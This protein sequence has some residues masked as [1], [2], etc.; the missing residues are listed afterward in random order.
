MEQTRAG[1]QTLYTDPERTQDDR[2]VKWRVVDGKQPLDL[3]KKGVY[4]FYYVP[5]RHGGPA[6][7][8]VD[9]T[10]TPST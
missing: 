2:T 4:S 10:G 6:T 7:A 9:G 3:G 8:N 5:G 1:S